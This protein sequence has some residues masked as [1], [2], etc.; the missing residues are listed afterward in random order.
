MIGKIIND[1]YRL[2]AEL[3]H[4]GMGA[5]YKGYDQQ[6]EREVAIKVLNQALF[7]DKERDQLIHEARMIARLKHPN[8]VSVY[9]V[10]EFENSPYFVMEFVDG[11]SLRDLKPGDTDE[12]I[13]ICIHICRGLEHAHENGIVHRDLKPENVLLE[14]DGTVKLVDFGIARSDVTRFTSAGNIAGTVNY[15]APEIA[16]GEAVDGR[17]DLYSLGVMLYE[18]TTGQLPLTA[19]SLVGVISKH[20][21]EDPAPPNETNPDLPLELNELIIRLLSKDPDERPSTASELLVILKA[22]ESGQ[23]EEGAARISSQT[24]PTDLPPLHNLTLQ[25]SSFIGREEELNEIGGLLRDPTSR[26]VTLVGI[27]GIGK[28][29]LA[30]H[31]AWDALDIFPHGV[32][33]VELASL[34][35]AGFLPQ[36]VAS[37]FGVSAQ[38]AR[39]GQDET[40]VL[41]DYLKDKELLLVIDNCEH[42]VEACAKFAD[43]LLKGC[44]HVKLLATSRE[45][46]RIPGE[47]VFHVSPMGLP[48][49]ELP[50]EHLHA[51]EAIGLFV[52]RAESARRG[53]EFTADN[54]AAVTQICRQLDGIPLAIELAAARVKVI[55]PQQIAERLQDRFKHQ[56]T[57]S[58]SSFSLQVSRT[59]STSSIVPDNFPRISC[60]PPA[61]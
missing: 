17:A 9:D 29:R 47:T 22:G 53:F 50:V 45:D 11:N 10:G 6:L 31:V 1:R 5:V 52:E 39:E 51:Y 55:A 38:E 34:T 54:S 14:K 20:L 19:D 3:G 40:V 7:G 30:T 56:A 21:F 8:I 33:M 24:P 60:N 4:G 28:T 25:A 37:L 41:V 15:L 23:L 27:G 58:K 61:R 43:T 2:D 35:E 32:W 48:P 46:L 26:L 44:P 16:K 36:Q 57:P 18:L 13:R 49:D 59:S 12:I 42:L